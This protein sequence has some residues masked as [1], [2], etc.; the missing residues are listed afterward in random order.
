MTNAVVAVSTLMSLVFM[1]SALAYRFKRFGEVAEG[2]PS[3]LVRR[4]EPVQE[5]MDRERIAAAELAAEVRKAGVE[6]VEDVKWAVLETGG[7]IT[8]IGYGP[9]DARTAPDEKGGE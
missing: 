4:G 2:R 7:R 6:R 1:T 9:D 8:I 3:L 5:T